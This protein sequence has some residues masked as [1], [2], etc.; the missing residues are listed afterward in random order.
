MFTNEGSGQMAGF[1]LGLILAM[2]I[3]NCYSAPLPSKFTIAT[4]AGSSDAHKIAHTKKWIRSG[5]VEGTL[6]GLLLGVGGSVVTKSPWPF[7]LCL[8]M[9]VWKIWS[10]ENA[11]TGSFADEAPKLDMESHDSQDVM[12]SS[13]RL[14]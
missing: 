3:P 2:E 4:F 10:Y 11:L 9:I 7:L 12:T 6:Q 13:P 5:E 14:G 1:G 8:G